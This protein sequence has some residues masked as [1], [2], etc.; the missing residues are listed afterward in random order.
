MQLWSHVYRQT[1]Y[2]E[3]DTDNLTEA[4]NHALRSQ[5]LQLRQDSSVT[6]LIEVLVNIVFPE[7]Q[8][9]YTVAVAQQTDA[10]RKPQYD[11]PDYLSDRPRNV[12]TACLANMSKAKQFISSDVTT[13]GDGVFTLKSN[14]KSYVVNIPGGYCECPYFSKTKIPCKHMFAIFS[15]FSEQW[16][17]HDLPCQLTECAYMTL[18]T[19]L[20]EQDLVDTIISEPVGELQDAFTSA[21][22]VGNTTENQYSD[23]V[24]CTMMDDGNYDVVLDNGDICVELEKRNNGENE[25]DKPAQQI[26]TAETS[27][28]KLRS[29]QKNAHTVL[30]KCKDVCYLTNDCSVLEAVIQNAEEIY[31]ELVESADPSNTSKFLPVFPVLAHNSA[32]ISRKRTKLLCR[33]TKPV[34]QGVSSEDRLE[35]SCPISNQQS[36]SEDRVSLVSTSDFADKKSIIDYSIYLN[37]TEDVN[38]IATNKNE[39]LNPS[40]NTGK[41]LPL[42]SISNK[43]QSS[44]KKDPLEAAKR[45]PLGRPKLRDQGEKSGNS[46]DKSVRELVKHFSIL[47]ND[48]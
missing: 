12:Q 27:T 47:E 36:V 19:S 8:H 17:W 44:T 34:Q 29:L 39:P 25:I 1:F 30:T 13:D 40:S 42:Q 23:A 28:H 48:S 26:P 15:L 33:A 6:D 31:C 45:N 21:V 3:I 22:T 14:D 11:I 37:S 35:E 16:S 38:E 46:L 10:Y 20:L 43:L 32:N 41:A 5:Y 24:I 7:Q 2:A 9:E 4:F 18:E